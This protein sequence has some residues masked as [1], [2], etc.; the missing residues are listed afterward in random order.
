MVLPKGRSDS[1]LRIWNENERKKRKKKLMGEDFVSVE[2][3]NKEGKDIRRE[4]NRAPDMN[5]I[6]T[7]R[8]NINAFADWAEDK[9]D[10]DS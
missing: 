8:E 2:K 7:Q 10:G 6:K 3:R 5:R 9:K 1:E 4:V